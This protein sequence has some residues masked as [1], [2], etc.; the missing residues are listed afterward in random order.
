MSSASVLDASSLTHVGMGQVVCASDGATMT[1]VLG[2]CIG[3]AL[4]HGRLRLGILAH[5]VLPN[6]AG[7]QST[8]GK[9]ADTAVPHMLELLASHGGSLSGAIAKLAG[10]ASM[11]GAGGAMQIGETNLQAVREALRKANLPVVAE[12]VGGVKGRRI[13]L[14]AATGKLTIE[15]VGCTAGLL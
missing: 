13:T 7:R 3:I 6:S 9:F 1:S 2:S 8:P 5:V 12:H 15:I 4:Y 14:D 11:F 10:G